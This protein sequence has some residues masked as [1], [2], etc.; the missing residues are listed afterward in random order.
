M[1][2]MFS[3]C[4]LLTK[5]EIS[6]LDTKNVICMEDMF[7]KCSSLKDIDVSNFEINHRCNMYHMFDGCSDELKNQIKSQ[8]KNF[9]KSAFESPNYDDMFYYL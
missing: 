7:F 2:R 3:D 8:N 5:L 6:D 9:K 4:K 1:K